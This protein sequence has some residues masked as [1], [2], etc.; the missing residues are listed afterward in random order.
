[1]TSKISFINI[2]IED[3]K[4]RIWPLA[5]AITGFFFALPVLALIKIEDHLN[6]LRM[7]YDIL[8]SLQVSF[9]QYTL[10][11]SNYF[12]I[13]GL[14]IM[15]GLNALT[16][17]KYLHSRQ[18]T[19][20][21]GSI[22]MLRTAR[23]LTAY[24]NGILTAIVPF[25]FMHILTAVFGYLNGLVTNAGLVC[26][27]ETV[28]LE[29]AGFILLYTFI[30]LATILTG[31]TA[32]SISGALILLFAPWYYYAVLS[33]YARTFFVTLYDT[34][35][36]VLWYLSPAT[37][38]FHLIK[39]KG[40]SY[41][42][43]NLFMALIAI[44][45]SALVLA[46]NLYL[47][48]KRPAEAATKAMAFDKT[49]PVIKIL[50]LVPLA[51]SAG[52]FFE[53]VTTAN[54]YAWLAFGLL[55]GLILGHSAIE[56]IYEFDFKACT[57]HI[58]SGLIAAA[59]AALIALFFIFDVPGY[60]TG[61]PKKDAIESGAIY[62]PGINSGAY[63]YD[64]YS[65]DEDN[66]DIQ[67]SKEMENMMLKDTSD[68]YTLAKA[69]TDWAASNRWRNND[70][71]PDPESIADENPDYT[72]ISIYLR[73]SSGRVFKRSYYVD[74]K[75]PDNYDALRRI[76]DTDE[77][78]KNTYD[79]YRM[80]E[81][82][83]ASRA[84]LLTYDTGVYS[85]NTSSLTEAK[86]KGLMDTIKKDTSGLTLDYIAK[87]APIGEVSINVLDMESLYD[88]ST[89]TVPLGYVYPSFTA[90]LSLLKEYGVFVNR[91][92]T[93]ADIDFIK[94]TVWTEDYTS[95]DSET[96]TASGEIA[97]LFPDL[98]NQSYYSVNYAVLSVTDTAEYEV[99][100]NQRLFSGLK[101]ID[102]YE[103]RFVQFYYLKKED[104]AGKL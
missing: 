9:T 98:V 42:L 99:H 16:G 32:V 25:V 96:I 78:K 74:L 2:L 17:M 45:V 73:R 82:D 81:T 48:K 40:I 31:H 70:N 76:Y 75:D 44:A 28:L 46:L 102:D 24:T 80:S 29:T 55:A 84:Q 7:G 12:A 52:S 89:Y 23:F 21:Y 20:F 4:R 11:N 33:G 63:Y 65:F 68:L 41:T 69:G 37:F 83:Y 87:E 19:D 59:I 62:I 5:L 90:T 36:K 93:P 49:R 35:D 97:K 1:M 26:G 88:G 14:F 34:H 15:A 18:E 72:Q 95:S 54:G 77:Y 85:D 43:F 39:G 100:F 61:L 27:A 79:I 3:L 94:K 60:D 58:P 51:L 64:Q 103:A 47:I 104:T 67:G 91:E 53:S 50:I 30:V 56:I 8:Q 101:N 92:I 66:Y 10:G 57:K 71:A 86:I 13:T 38:F 6:S 22:P